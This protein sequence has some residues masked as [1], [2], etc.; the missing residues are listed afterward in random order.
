MNQ[1]LLP[2]NMPK[3]TNFNPAHK[4]IYQIFDTTG[5]VPQMVNVWIPICGVHEQRKTGLP[6]APGSHLFLESQIERTKAGVY[7]IHKI[8]M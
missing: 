4:D 8:I 5:K 1:K 2:D 3:S 6:L 7:L